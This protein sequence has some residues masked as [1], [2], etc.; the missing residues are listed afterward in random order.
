[1]LGFLIIPQ[2]LIRD[3]VSKYCQ[4]KYLGSVQI[5]CFQQTLVVYMFSRLLQ[6]APGSRDLTTLA[7][8]SVILFVNLLIITVS[9]LSG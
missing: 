6:L 5:V 8:K 3:T 7:E 2:L 1:M 4:S 9:L